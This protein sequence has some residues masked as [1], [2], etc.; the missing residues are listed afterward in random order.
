MGDFKT[1]VSHSSH[2]KPNSVMFLVCPATHWWQQQ[3]SSTICYVWQPG[4]DKLFVSMCLNPIFSVRLCTELHTLSDTSPQICLTMLQQGSDAEFNLC[5]PPLPNVLLFPVP[6][7]GQQ[8]VRPWNKPH[9]TDEDSISINL[10]RPCADP[11]KLFQHAGWWNHR[12]ADCLLEVGLH[13][14]NSGA[15]F[16][17]T[18]LIPA[19]FSAWRTLDEEYYQFKSYWGTQ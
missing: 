13:W 19:G 15:L 2:D 12:L 7:C 8:I 5:S 11:Q 4:R 6:R 17:Q 18:E 16:K 9:I 1:A 10:L 3:V 14:I